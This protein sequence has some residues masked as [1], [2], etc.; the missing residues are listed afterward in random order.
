[1]SRLASLSERISYRVDNRMIWN[2]IAK[3]IGLFLMS[4]LHI[5]LG[6]ALY[7][8]FVAHESTLGWQ[9]STGTTLNPRDKQARHPWPAGALVVLSEN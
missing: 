8:D 4:S 7:D 1:M 5:L 9:D 2:P 6:A 3:I